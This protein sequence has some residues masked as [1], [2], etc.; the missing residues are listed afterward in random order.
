L[1]E[2]ARIVR[3]RTASVKH[4]LEVPIHYGAWVMKWREFVAVRIDADN[5]AS[6]FSYGLTR[7][8]PVE[9]IVAKS[10]APRYIGTS[11]DDI[12]ATFYDT[13]W[14]NHAVHQGAIGMRAL[15]VV[16]LA[17]WDL[18]ARIAGVPV[19]KLAGDHYPGRDQPATAIVAYPPSMPPEY[20]FNQVTELR[21]QGWRRFKVPIAPTEEATIARLEAARAAAPDDWVGYDGNMVYRSAE[22]VIEFEKKVRH[23]KLGW[24]EDMVPPGDARLVKRIH[25][26][27]ETPLAMG[28]EQGGAYFPSA[29]VDAGA[30]DVVRLDATTDGGVTMLKKTVQDCIARGQTISPHMFPHVH[31]Q[32]FSAWDIEVPIEWGV[33]GTGVHP[34]DDALVQPVIVDGMM[35]PLPEAPGFGR[36][37]D[38]EWVQQQETTDPDG[39]LDDV[40][41][42][43]K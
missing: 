3:I 41:N 31:S 25:D 12:E 30:V 37:I 36:L 5:G 42:L 40:E 23:L 21:A 39:L 8:G 17:A 2:P 7:E 19:G 43:Q 6:G 15:S 34:M 14:S 1:T 35:K 28:D 27:I 20:V 16:D 29:L 32:L 38:L 10:I 4:M 11:V 18:K 33:R 9:A 22:Q 13:L 26:G 24:I